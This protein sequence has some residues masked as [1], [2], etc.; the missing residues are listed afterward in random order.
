MTVVIDA[1]LL[2]SLAAND[3]R[4]EA[5]D[6]MFAGWLAAGEEM[7]APSLTSFE[8]ANGL[9]RLVAGG[10][11][12]EGRVAS[13]W[14]AAQDLPI[15]YHQLRDAP[16][17]IRLA[18]QLDRHSAY[19]AAYL[20]LARELGATCWTLDGRLVRNASQLGLPVRLVAT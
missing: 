19:D 12:P 17:V 16:P 7:H 20:T 15:T 9:T 2:V 10:A 14:Q 4:A 6:G 5:V 18:R 13:A 8:L 3:P 1:S 11:M